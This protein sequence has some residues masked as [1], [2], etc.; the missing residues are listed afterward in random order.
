MNSNTHMVKF[1]N[2][3]G[4]KRTEYFTDIQEMKKACKYYYSVGYEFEIFMLVP[5]HFGWEEDW[6]EETK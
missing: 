6:K 1:E 2:K 4:F 3:Y 5:S